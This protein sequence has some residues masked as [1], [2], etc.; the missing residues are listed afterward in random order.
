M[1]SQQ[2]SAVSLYF[3]TT[4][5]LVKYSDSVFNAACPVELLHEKEL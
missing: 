4:H 2:V 5:C 1:Y 3:H